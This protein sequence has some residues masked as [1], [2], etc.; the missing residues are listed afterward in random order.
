[1]IEQKI[2]SLADQLKVLAPF[3]AEFSV[4]AV[5]AEVEVPEP[6]RFG[7]GAKS[8]I[9]TRQQNEYVL[10]LNRGERNE[11]HKPI[12]LESEHLVQE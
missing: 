11:I 10:I 7:R 9:F 6:T 4:D 8:A 12:R 3:A 5:E 2:L 1:M